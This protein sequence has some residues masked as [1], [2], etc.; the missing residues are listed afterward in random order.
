MQIHLDQLHQ[1]ILACS[2]YMDSDLPVSLHK[3]QMPHACIVPTLL[4][5]ASIVADRNESLHAC[6]DPQI[7]QMVCKIST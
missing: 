7:F 6:M 4:K 1:Q 3:I 5:E 2:M